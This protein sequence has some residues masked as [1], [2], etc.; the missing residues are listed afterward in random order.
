MLPFSLLIT[1]VFGASKSNSVEINEWLEKSVVS[2]DQIRTEISEYIQQLIPSFNVPDRTTWEHQASALR[3]EILDK[4]V[5][6]GVPHEWIDW[7]AETMWEDTLEVGPGYQIRKL[8]YHA[9]PG[10]WIPA[11]LYEPIQTQAK[12]PAILNVNG[13]VGPPG[14]S[15]DYEQLRCINLAKKGV[16]ALHPEW[17]YFGELAGEDYK[18]NRMAYLDLCGISGLS[19]FYLAMRGGL[20]VLYDY[21]STD[22]NRVG[23][24]GLSGGG[25]QT[26]ILSALDERISLS[27]PNAGYIDLKNRIDYRSDIGD[28]EQ[29]PTDLVSI[30]DY[31][32]LTGMLAPRPTLLLYNQKDDCCF[33]AERA[34]SAV[35]HPA[36]PFFQLFEKTADFVYYENKD[37]GTHNYDLDN[38][39][40][41]YR[42]VKKHYA[43]LDSTESEIPSEAELLTAEQLTV[44]LPE[45]NANFFTLAKTYLESL[46]K[47]PVPM[48]DDTE[49]EQWQESARLRLQQVLRLS[50]LAD[51]GIT[52]DQ[53]LERESRNSVKIERY[54][55][56]T[57]DQ[58]TLPLMVFYPDQLQ[59]Q[60]QNI[61]IALADG[62]QTQMKDR[63][64]K[65][66][67]LGNTVII[68]DLLFIGESVPAGISPWQYAMLIATV[69]KRPLGIQVRQL[70][71]L[72][73]WV[74]QKYQVPQISLQ[75]QGWNSGIVVLAA[76]G[77]SP[78][79]VK[80]INATEALVDLKVLINQHLDYENYPAL[81]CFGLLEE[82]NVPELMALSSQVEIQYEH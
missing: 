71:L 39:E 18:H 53:L 34:E 82:F 80:R 68:V 77:L 33:V 41:F 63:I 26:I 78:G 23:M 36:I 37:P 52:A 73:E 48:T 25:W 49:Q 61:V 72:V 29:N 12:M 65:E 79:R 54:Q 10:L 13:H 24:T 75:S 56:R 62:G 16:L 4:V 27:V 47:Y 11:L 76:S 43:L 14:K 45:G 8:R 20:D 64:Q 57:T 9:L 58:L 66:I 38:R 60:N 67:S 40:Q 46:P 44:G 42:F 17:F 55:L 3:Q 69:G 7:K 32:Y 35:Y 21:P 2:P 6:R 59:H 81:F 51:D 50:P 28:L 70:Q 1:A 31:T 22:L 5:F 15:T 30:A 74:C 19:T